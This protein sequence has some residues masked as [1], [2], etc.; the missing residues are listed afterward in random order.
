MRVLLYP[1]GEDPRFVE[2]DG[3]LESMQALVGGLIEMV[4]L[5]EGIDIVVNEEGKGIGLSPNR[6][7]IIRD[8]VEDV[9]Y[10]AFFVCAVNEDG[11]S[12]ELTDEQLKRTLNFF[13]GTRV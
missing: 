5:D 8:Q 13:E 1:V 9:F 11:E 12:I 6:M 7:W 10:G 2:I 3:G 4:E